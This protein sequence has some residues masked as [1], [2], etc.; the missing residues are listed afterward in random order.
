MTFKRVHSF[1][2]YAKFNVKLMFG[3]VFLA[4]V[5]LVSWTHYSRNWIQ[6][7]HSSLAM[8]GVSG[9]PR[10]DTSVY[11]KPYAPGLLWAFGEPGQAEIRVS[12]EFFSDQEIQSLR[13]LFPEA[14]FVLMR[15]GPYIKLPPLRLNDR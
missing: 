5:L 6:Q 3:F 10:G 8:T 12:K 15:R 13:E 11:D 14:M 1:V 7:R 4:S 2:R 9:N